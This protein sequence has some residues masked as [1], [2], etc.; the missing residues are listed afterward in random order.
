MSKPL[1]RR[2][3]KGLTTIRN[4]AK[5][6][7]LP[8]NI[9]E[10][11]GVFAYYMFPKWG[12]AELEW[13]WFHYYQC[14]YYQS[15]IDGNVDFMSVELAPQHGKTVLLTLFIVYT[16]G[17]NPNLNIIYYTY[18]EERA[19]NV[20]KKNILTQMFDEKYRKIFPH[21]LLKN[22]LPQKDKDR[23]DLKQSKTA[24]LKDNEFTLSNPFNKK[25]YKGSLLAKGMDQG[26]QGR[27]AD[28]SLI[29][30]YVA[31]GKDTLSLNFKNKRKQWFYT[32]CVS[33]FQPNTKM[34]IVCTRWYNDD[35]VGQLKSEMSRI[36]QTMKDMGDTPPEYK[37]IRIRAEYRS[38]EDNPQEDPRT[39]DGE[40]LWKPFL[41][42]YLFVKNSS[43]YEAMY[44]CDPRD[45]DGVNQLS[46]TDFGYYTELPQFGG[47][48]YFSIDPASSDK[49][50]ADCTAIGMWLVLGEKRYLVR[51]WSLKKSIPD[52]IDFITDLL[53]VQYPDYY[54]CLI[55]HAS[56]GIAISQFLREKNIRHTPLSFTGR[57]VGEKA[58]DTTS[59]TKQT[60]SKMERYLRVIPEFKY[61]DKRILLPTNQIE[62]QDEFI[63]QMITFDGENGKK[64]DFV[65][66]CT[67]LV[68]YVSKSVINVS[69]YSITSS[70]DT[71]DNDSVLNYGN[72]LS[73]GTGQFNYGF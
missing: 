24:T 44:N 8:E 56:S 26:T 52:L 40:W 69:N 73:Y 30:D 13:E 50:K 46:L 15:I 37:E 58:T 27:A 71:S 63:N 47:R 51:L 31:S 53:T 22:D 20:V 67:Y 23:A 12:D 45:Y 5:E 39:K 29:D 4:Y 70:N 9:Y 18:N 6:N 35:I 42:K 33:R 14:K 11:F 38:W 54:D 3:P 66:M 59:I 2:T 25:N 19:V 72:G 28:L 41:V 49:K 55:E 10:D 57:R 16:F 43:D 32:D 61:P 62:H 36:Y 60:N 34:V 1:V 21:V 68:Y 65:D 17:I 48:L 7:N 64:D